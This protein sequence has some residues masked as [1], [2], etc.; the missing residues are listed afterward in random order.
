MLFQAFSSLCRDSFIPTEHLKSCLLVRRPA[1]QPGH[2]QAT[3][4]TTSNR[5][6]VA[7]P[8]R[9]RTCNG[10]QRLRLRQK[11]H[12]NAMIARLRHPGA[13]QSRRQSILISRA[14]QKQPLNLQP[15]LMVKT[16]GP[17]A[18]IL[19]H[20]PNLVFTPV[21][22]QAAV[23]ISEARAEVVTTCRLAAINNT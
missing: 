23:D 16:I 10:R 18:Q 6:H 8:M 19:V 22:E 7:A 12:G 17:H 2:A 21:A 20:V 14:D 1:D 13:G 9:R 3:S 4:L 5:W 15:A 11:M